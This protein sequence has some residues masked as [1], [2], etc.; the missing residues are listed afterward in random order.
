MLGLGGAVV[1]MAPA[2]ALASAGEAIADAGLTTYPLAPGY[3]VN[4]RSGPGTNCSIVDVLPEGGYV[5]I[6]CQGP[7][8]WV[9]G[10]YGTTDLGDCTGNGRFISDAT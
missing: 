5:T 7:G 8:T 10:P 2:I 6:R 4:V 9:S 1:A 3:R